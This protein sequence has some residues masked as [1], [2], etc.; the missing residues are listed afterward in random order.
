MDEDFWGVLVG[1]YCLSFSSGPQTKCSIFHKFL[2]SSSHT[3]LRKKKLE[4]AS[5]CSFMT[6]DDV[7]GVTK[8]KNNIKY[9]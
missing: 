2:F 6:F 1:L 3:C 8:N 9:R 5:I 7:T 4:N